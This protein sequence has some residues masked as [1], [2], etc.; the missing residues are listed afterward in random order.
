MAGRKKKYDHDEIWKLYNDGL[1]DFQISEAVGCS[2]DYVKSL[3]GEKRLP[4]NEEKFDTGK[5]KALHNAGWSNY[6]IA[7]EMGVDVEEIKER[8]NGTFKESN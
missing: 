7:D 8:L 6:K 5:M 1:T 3:R 4:Q 2:C